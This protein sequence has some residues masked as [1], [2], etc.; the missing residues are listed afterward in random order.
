MTR[1]F[2]SR[3]TRVS[4]YLTI[5]RIFLPIVKEFFLFYNKRD[6]PIPQYPEIVLADYKI[7]DTH[8]E[9]IALN[10]KEVEG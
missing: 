1:K 4:C 8:R 6:I 7:T 3:L 10:G 2:F 9:E 5:L